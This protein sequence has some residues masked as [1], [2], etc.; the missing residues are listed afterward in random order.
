MR[1]VL[2]AARAVALQK[3]I[4][5]TKAGR[6]RAAT[7]SFSGTGAAMRRIH[8]DEVHVELDVPQNA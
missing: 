8:D 6:T 7:Q 1:S 4:I 2:S 3:P 5:V